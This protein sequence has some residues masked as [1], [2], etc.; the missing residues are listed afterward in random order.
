MPD[1]KPLYDHLAHWM[2]IIGW[3]L[4]WG[5]MGTGMF[6]LIPDDIATVA[7]MIGG[8][9]VVLSG[10]MIFYHPAARARALQRMRDRPKT[11]ASVH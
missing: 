3:I 4:F 9:L 6:S 5:S 11:K 2:C 1:K 8:G 7:C 10:C